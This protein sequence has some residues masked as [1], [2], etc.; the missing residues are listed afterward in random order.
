MG[1]TIRLAAL[2]F[3]LTAGVFYACSDTVEENKEMQTEEPAPVQNKHEL[4]VL[5]LIDGEGNRVNLNAFK[6]RKVFVNLWATWC[7]PCREEIPSIEAL[8]AKPGNE[9]IAFVMLS[10]DENF[11]VARQFAKANKMKL[12]V[13]YPAEKL[14]ALFNVEGIPATFIFNELGQLV[15]QVNGSEDYSKMNI[16]DY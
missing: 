2:V 3:I 1:I 11:D 15:K 8:A 12:Q 10:L 9:N 16:M 13:Y 7:P 14:P 4:P 5:A 6:G